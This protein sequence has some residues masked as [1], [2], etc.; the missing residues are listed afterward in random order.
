MIGF[1]S[2]INRKLLQNGL[3]VDVSGIGYLVETPLS[4]L[5]KIPPEGSKVEF[6][7]HTLVREDSLRLFGFQ[8]YSEKQVFQLLVGLSGVGP[9]VGLAVLSTIGL[10]G[11][12]N[13]ARL[14]DPKVLLKVPGIGPRLAEKLTVELKSKTEQ[15][16]NAMGTG[17]ENSDA[18]SENKGLAQSEDTGTDNLV[19]EEVRSALENLGFKIKA[20]EPVLSEISREH[21]GS[22]FQSVL[23][24]ALAKI[25]P[26]TNS[27]YA[28]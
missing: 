24:L 14:S 19:L 27:N 23:K 9:K 17:K 8:S 3:I 16:F 26:K 11:V 13:C 25:S 1:L 20:I 4:T 10:K 5:V 15:I 22:T 2:G 18:L 28:N 12:I 6:W 7:V 21:V